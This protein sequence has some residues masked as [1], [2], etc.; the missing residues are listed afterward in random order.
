MIQAEQHSPKFLISSNS[1]NLIVY[2][3]MTFNIGN[4]T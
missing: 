1:L 3:K 2:D 4:L